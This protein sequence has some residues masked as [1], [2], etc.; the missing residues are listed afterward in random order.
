MDTTTL[1][2]MLYAVY[3]NKEEQLPVIDA[4]CFDNIEGLIRLGLLARDDS[5]KVMID[6]PVIK[7]N[8]RWELYKLSDKYDSEITEKLGREFEALLEDP[9]KLP[10]HLRSVPDWQRYMECSSL[11]KM[12][13]IMNA[14]ENGL[15][16]AGRNFEENPIPAVF[17]AMTE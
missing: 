16:F 6:I 5:G 17:L 15:F 9:V 13:I 8:D 3:A 11:V 2:K 12:M 7:M 10:P 1:T 4:H 14:H